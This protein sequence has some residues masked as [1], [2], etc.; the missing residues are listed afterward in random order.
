[1]SYWKK[2]E[3]D[4]N[5][6]VKE[7]GYDTSVTLS[8][9]NR[10]DL[11]EFQINDAMRLAKEYHKSPIEI[12][13]DIKRVL[14]E[15]KNF[16]DIN[17][18]GAGFI[19]LSLTDQCL[20]SFVNEIKDNIENNI[21]KMEPKN[22][23]I[24]YGGANVA[25]ALHVGH[26]RSANIGEALNRLAKA[27]GHK[28]ISDAHLGDAGLQAGLVVLEMKERFPELLCFQEGYNGEDFELPIVK[29][30]L[31]EIYPTASNK[32]KEDEN[33]LNEARQITYQIQKNNIAYTKLWDKLSALSI[34]DIKETYERLNAKFD[35][36]EGERDSF[37][38][39]PEMF[40]LLKEKGLTYVSDGATVM[41][42]KEDTD[43][44]E[45]PPILLQK[46]DGA[47]LYATTDLATI[48]GRMKR[49]PIDEIWYTTDI[50][51]ELHFTQVFRA[52]YKSG[53][54]PESVKLG[55]YGFGTMNGS[56]GKPFKT[57]TGGVMPLNELI[58]LI[59]VECRKRLNENIVE[60]ENRDNV[61]ETIALAALKY[62][63]LLP[64]RATD[65]IFD[66]A[67]F[68]DLDGKTGPYL[69]YS[70]I[71]MKSL[72]N[73]AK[74]ENIEYKNYTVIKNNT[75]KDVL[76]T[77]LNLPNVL[78]RAYESKS[79]NEVTDYIYK[80]TSSYNKFYSE[81]KVLTEENDNLR[82]S[83]LVLSKTVWET[84][85]M[86]LNIMGIDC[87]EKM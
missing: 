39:I 9:S 85:M 46:S 60:E 79:L 49:F 17:I 38:Y 65:Y 86:L 12:A 5:K 7:A 72:L 24:D 2:L 26:L 54:V 3:E 32:S 42:V 53:I 21:D 69:L 51:Q 78:K 47:Y 45:M 83:W 71:R 27:L 36:W 19:N 31:K 56:D 55:F 64:F 1:M 74:E 76:L 34:V 41:D 43:D 23:V 57:R 66:P 58:D 84:N 44:K 73:K 68:S 18:A 33:F 13:N 63:D 15:D 81:N 16:K 8:L 82:E 4:L 77:L 40:D 70:T 62:A 28:T 80:L 37:Q 14:D 67:K 22:I 35:L 87:P 10:P 6:A 75:D 25:K 61:S 59:K 11:G 48:Y 52:A 29:E 20:T 30:D 50:R